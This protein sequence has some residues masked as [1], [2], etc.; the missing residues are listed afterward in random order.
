VTGT[1]DA[2]RT[3][4]AALTDLDRPALG[5]WVKLPSVEVVEL[6]ANA[7]FD[8]V[9]IDLEH[10]PLSVETAATLIAVARLAGVAPVVRVPGLA[11]GLVGRVLDAGAAGVMVPHVDSTAN[12]RAAV[13]TV[14]FPPLGERGAGSTSRAGLWGALPPKEYVRQGQDDVVLIAQ[15]ESRAACENAADVAATDGVDAVLVGVADL[16]LSEGRAADDPVVTDLVARAVRAARRAGVPV[17]TAGAPTKDAAAA[18]FSAG[19]TFTM[20]GNDAGLLG[21][22]MRSAVAGA[23]AAA[24]SVT[25]PTHQETT[26]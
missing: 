16:S 3:L 18:A 9:V 24:D 23:R 11:S 8:L 26:P 10:S 2:P 1:S 15:L 4:R 25:A 5:T 13:A 22:A 14:R 12:A 20:L 6:A 17:G 21:A 19:F 7:G